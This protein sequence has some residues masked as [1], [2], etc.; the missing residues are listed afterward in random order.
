MRFCDKYSDS[1]YIEA[2]GQHS[3]VLVGDKGSPCKWRGLNNAKRRVIKYRVDGG[4]IASKTQLKC[5]SA[6]YVEGDSV[7]LIELKGADYSHAL[8]QIEA[9]V[10]KLI[11]APAIET[12]SVNGRIVLTRGKVPG[13]RYSK[14][15]ALEKKLK[16]LKGTL[17]SKTRLFEEE[18]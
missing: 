18:I 13:I 8:E 5:D 17:R 14:E 1:S 3:V 6:V 7:Y 15:T 10:D 16:R 12:S 9:T 2:D 11:F 4:I